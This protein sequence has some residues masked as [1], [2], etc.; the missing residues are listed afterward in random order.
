MYVEGRIW[1]TASPSTT[2]R[3][4]QCSHLWSKESGDPPFLEAF[5][6]QAYIKKIPRLLRGIVS[7]GP[8]QLWA[9]ELVP[10]LGFVDVLPVGGVPPWFPARQVSDATLYSRSFLLKPFS[11]E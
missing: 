11:G 7:Q 1:T 9:T 10:T 5:K 6:G 4:L 2:E 3:G 8:G